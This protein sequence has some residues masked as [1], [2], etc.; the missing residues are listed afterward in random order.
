MTELIK[1]ILWR[2]ELFLSS[3]LW[4]G[5]KY[6]LDKMTLR[7]LIK[8]YFAYPAIRVYIFLTIIS[9][10]LTT[11]WADAFLPIVVSVAAGISI[12]GLAWYLLHRFFLHGKFLYKLPQTSTLWKRIH[13][14]HHQDPNDLEVLFGALNT[15]LPTIFIMTVPIGLLISG[16]AG[17]AAACGRALF[18]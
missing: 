3:K 17:G 9:G 8:A 6:H 4:K 18:R 7:E 16:P 11:F 14:D 1:K 10:G 12:Y 2:N 15:T 5:Q 13:F